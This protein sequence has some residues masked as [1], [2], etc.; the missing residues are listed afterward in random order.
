MP[1]GDPRARAWTAAY[2]RAHPSATWN[3]ANTA[4]AAAGVKMSIN[5]FYRWRNELQRVGV[6]AG[7]G[8]GAT[9]ASA[10]TPRATAG[11]TRAPAGRPAATLTTDDI[12]ETLRDELHRTA[13]M[14]AAL[15]EIRDILRD[16]LRA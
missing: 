16:T 7:A 4:A 15:G 10:V 12:V 9:V 13:K 14:R 6:A 1:P 8:P 5:S 2:L 3:E 11:Q